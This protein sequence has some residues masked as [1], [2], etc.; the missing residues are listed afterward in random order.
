MV[1]KLELQSKMTK[2]KLALTKEYARNNFNI[3]EK[4]PEVITA[5]LIYV[6]ILKC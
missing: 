4:L 5:I 3:Y 1:V 6:V 2:L